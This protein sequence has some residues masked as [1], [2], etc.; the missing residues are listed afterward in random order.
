MPPAVKEKSNDAATMLLRR[1]T[2]PRAIVAGLIPAG[3]TA[4]V[5][6]AFGNRSTWSRRLVS[7][8]E[9]LAKTLTALAFH[10][11]LRCGEQPV[12]SIINLIERAEIRLC[13]PFSSTIR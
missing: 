13:W 8:L 2:F 6:Q 12:P 4:G 9:H 1:G 10:L 7:P 5:V 3:G 11:V